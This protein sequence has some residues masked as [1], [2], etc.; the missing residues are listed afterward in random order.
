MDDATQRGGPYIASRGFTVRSDPHRIDGTG[1][2]MLAA[3]RTPCIKVCVVDGE[4]GFCLGCAR[5]LGEI[6]QWSRLSDDERDAVMTALPER[7]DKLKSL[8]KLG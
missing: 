7:M 4:T 1:F 6:A 3:I 2:A 8:G 5:K